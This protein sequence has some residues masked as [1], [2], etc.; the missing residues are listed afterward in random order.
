[1]YVIL[2]GSLPRDKRKSLASKQISDKYNQTCHKLSDLIAHVSYVLIVVINHCSIIKTGQIHNSRRIKSW[3]RFESYATGQ[4]CNFLNKLLLFNIWPCF[5]HWI[6]LPSLHLH[7]SP[8][9]V[10]LKIFYITGS[11]RYMWS[12]YSS[13]QYLNVCWRFQ[14][15]AH[16]WREKMACCMESSYAYFIN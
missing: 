7:V 3:I 14:L 11:W 9:F 1:M 13:I 2:N 8:H 6:I 12:T 10:L 5:A 16:Q 4:G 15:Q